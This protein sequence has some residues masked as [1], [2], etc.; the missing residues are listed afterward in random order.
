MNP[1]ANPTCLLQVP[2]ESRGAE[3]LWMEH[4]DGGVAARG[5]HVGWGRGGGEMPGHCLAGIPPGRQGGEH[6]DSDI[7]ILL[8]RPPGSRPQPVLRPVYRDGAAEDVN[9]GAQDGAV[10]Q[11]HGVVPSLLHLSL[12][13]RERRGLPTWAAGGLPSSRC[14]PQ[15]Q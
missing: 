10:G 5:P 13:E 11:G 4:L 14:L 6:G 9:G 8:S 2:W 7:P 1:K 15:T 12:Q 3:Q